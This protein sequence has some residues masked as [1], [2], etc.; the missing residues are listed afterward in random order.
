MSDKKRILMLFSGGLDSTWLLYNRIKEGC[1]VETFYAKG[2]QRE[3]KQNCEKASRKLIT[4]WIEANAPADKPASIWECW[5]GQVE[6]R[7]GAAKK[8]S[9]GQAI[10]WLVSALE[11]VDPDKHYCVEIGYVMGDEICQHLH[12]IQDAWNSL[13]KFSKEGDVVPLTFPLSRTKKY[14][15][16]QQMPGELYKLTWVCELPDVDHLNG[17]KPC[18]Q[19]EACITRATE[20]HRFFLK[21]GMTVQTFHTPSAKLIEN[22]SKGD[23]NALPVDLDKGLRE[24]VQ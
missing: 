18:G 14:E 10:A 20:E 22:G 13:W 23:S 4:A 3:S 7:F 24:I 11:V 15:I 9:W 12:D 6:V 5:D 8:R 1:L 2:G 19:C 16:L 21:Q 17:H